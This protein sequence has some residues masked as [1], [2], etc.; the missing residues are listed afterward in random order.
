MNLPVRLLFGPLGAVILFAGIV[1]L[2]LMVPGYSHVHQ[3]V[4]EIGEMDSPA[5][6]PF[7]VMLC[8]VALCILVF[9]WGVRDV[10]R[11]AHHSTFAAYVIG[12]MA[13]S[14][15]G[16]AI[17]AFPH[18]LHNKF[19]LSEIVGYTAPLILALTWRRDRRAKGLVAFSW[20]MFVAVWLAIALNMSSMNRGGALWAALKPEYGLVQRALFVTWFGWIAVV[21]LLL[22]RRARERIA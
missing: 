1:G 19:G 11:A 14:V 17:F 12:F 18:P 10:S 15:T 5:R 8:V 13:V 4:S 2:A 20:I 21:G 6:I 16:V 9:A 22:Y 7:A 3:T